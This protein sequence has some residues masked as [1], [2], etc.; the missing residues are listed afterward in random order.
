MKEKVQTLSQSLYVFKCPET[1]LNSLIHYNE[2]I[3]WSSVHQ[4]GKAIND[5]PLARPGKSYSSESGSLT[6]I[7]KLESVHSWI[8]DCFNSVVQTI[9]WPVDSIQEIYISQS[10]LNCSCIGELHHRHT[11]SLSILSSILYL[12]NNCNTEFYVPSIYTLNTPFGPTPTRLDIKDTFTAKKGDLIIF[13]ST[14]EHSV[15]PN[16]TPFPRITLS[17]NSWFKG[18][19]GN[20]DKLA[21][22]G[23]FKSENYNHPT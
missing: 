2:T 6:E 22:I 10:W 12:T 11:H 23:S 16:L 18:S 20:V 5:N 19:I 17:C 3:N 1:E 15:E 21:Y 4:R 7:K 14:L 13:P 8:E 9:G